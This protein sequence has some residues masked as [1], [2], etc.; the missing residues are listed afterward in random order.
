MLLA[1]YNLT[2]FIIIIYILGCVDFCIFDQ[3]LHKILVHGAF[4]SLWPRD[5]RTVTLQT[6][7]YRHNG[8]HD[9][10]LSPLWCKLITAA[11]T[12]PRFIIATITVKLIMAAITV[13]WMIIADITV[14]WLIIAAITVP[15]DYW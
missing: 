8:N 12:V 7:Y 2:F 14:P 11:I 5:F 3:R 15:I 1:I 4:D 10:L 13:P 9:W 6:D